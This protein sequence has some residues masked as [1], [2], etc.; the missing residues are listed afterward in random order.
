MTRE[1]KSI[2]VSAAER[3]AKEFGYDQV[4][5][6]GRRVGAEGAPHGEHVTTYGIDRTHCAVAARLGDFFKHHLMKWPQEARPLDDWH[7]DMGPVLWWAF[8]VEEAPWAGD[9]RSSAWPGYHT[10]FTPLPEAPV[11]PSPA[12]QKAKEGRADAAS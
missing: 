6:I 4:V 11:E 8:P 5:I 2:P 7:E 12:P 9:P 10:H 1:M 3:V